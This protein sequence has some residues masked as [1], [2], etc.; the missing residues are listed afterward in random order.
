MAQKPEEYKERHRAHLDQMSY[1][2][3]PERRAATFSHQLTASGSRLEFATTCV[4]LHIQKGPL[5]HKTSANHH[6]A[7]TS[8]SPLRISY[9][10]PL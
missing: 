10:G 5:E 6:L 7:T 1:R 8:L 9:P 4:P 3:N 2:A